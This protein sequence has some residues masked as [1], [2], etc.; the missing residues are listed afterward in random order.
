MDVDK[1]T[2]HLPQ[3]AMEWVML[4][5]WFC[6]FFKMALPENVMGN[7]AGVEKTDI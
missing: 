1:V 3:V 7:F 6:I 2:S 5:V 4:K